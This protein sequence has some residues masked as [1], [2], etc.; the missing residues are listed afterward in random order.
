MTGWGRLAP[1][2]LALQLDAVTELIYCLLLDVVQQELS[3]H[4][5]KYA[6][7]APKEPQQQTSKSKPG[8]M[9][10]IVS[11]A[12][13]SFASCAAMNALQC[14]RTVPAAAATCLC[15]MLS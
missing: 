2:H 1:L 15:H 7:P 5:I 9:P 10:G 6:A 14:C 8:P 11:I 13:S 4:L 12:I 3:L